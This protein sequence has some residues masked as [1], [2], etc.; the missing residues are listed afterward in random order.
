MGQASSAETH[1]VRLRQAT[2]EDVELLM[3]WQSSTSYTGEFNDFGLR[4][5]SPVKDSIKKNGLIG[6][7]GGTLIVVEG[8]DDKRIGTVSWH[9]VRYG[10]NPES[11]AWNIG[12]ALIPEARG[13]GFGGPAQRLLALYLF[14][15]TSANRVEASTDVENVAE[16]RA[17]EKAGFSR[18]GV[19]RGAQYR[20]GRWRDLVQY[21]V[22][23]DA[24]IRPA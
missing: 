11:F 5:P 9:Q 24:L 23:R 16:Q 4:S 21:S 15:T 22:V 6:E 7:S 19:S 8:A 13:R 2:L 17:L 20:A 14:A 10:P 3:L 18:E 12:I 1:R